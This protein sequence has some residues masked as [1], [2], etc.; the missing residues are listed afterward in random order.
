MKPGCIAVELGVARGEFSDALL[1]RGPET[2]HLTS[3]DRWSDHHD[4]AEE[5]FARGLLAQ[6]GK[7]SAVLKATFDEALM[8][9]PNNH[10]DFIY[11]DGYA[12]T[13][14]ENGQTLW[15]WWT[16][17]KCGGIFAG[18]DYHPQWPE[19]VA[20]VDRFIANMGHHMF[21]TPD[22]EFPSWWTVK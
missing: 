5:Q 4:A 15:R 22:D 9:F 1:L 13:G 3:V 11:I 12:H 2:M 6:H 17:L 7:R 8:M 20:Q 19:T 21:T 16:K 14:Q 18:H 10:F